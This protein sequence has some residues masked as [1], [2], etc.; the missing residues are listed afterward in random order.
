MASGVYGTIRPA[1]MLPS[2]VEMTVFYS[3]NRESSN[4]K[5]FSLDSANLIQINNPNNTSGFEIFSGLYTLRLP[6]S[7]FGT[8]GIYT[9]TFKP[10]EIRTKIVDCGVLSA[11]PDIKG[12][13]LD[14]SDPNTFESVGAFENNNL[15]GYRVEYINTDATAS[16]RKI[17]NFFRI[18]TS[19][20]RTEPINQNLT[21]VN[22]KAIRYRFNDNSTLT[23]C[24]LSPS[25][26]TNVNPNALPFIGSPNQEIIITNTFFS[27]F[28]MEVEIVDYDI[29]SLA[30]G[31]FGNQAKSLEDGIYTLYNFTNEIYKQYN[32]YEIKDRFTG[33]PLFEIKENRLNNIDFTKGFNDVSNT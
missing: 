28:M 4:T 16:D 19:N 24:T 5:I 31:M 14:T 7:E 29:E 22:Q 20:N 30:I 23:F 15:V 33:K 13:V 21:N 18:I 6:I 12:I 9:I 10:R 3:A 27:P 8:K 26:P 25:A 11:F 2:D 1:D 17:K 32:L